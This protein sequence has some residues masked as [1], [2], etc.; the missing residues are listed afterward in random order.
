[1]TLKFFL[2]KGCYCFLKSNVRKVMKESL[3]R[4]KILISWYWWW[5][6]CGG[7]Y[8]LPGE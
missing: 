4:Q 5:C 3:K 1:M 6:V 2:D 8:P 7:V